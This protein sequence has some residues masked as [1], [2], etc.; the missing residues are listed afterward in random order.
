MAKPTAK[1]SPKT[2]SVYPYHEVV[3]S[4]GL[5]SDAWVRYKADVMAFESAFRGKLMS[6]GFT[7][8]TAHLEE[9]EGDEV[10]LGRVRPIPEA[11]NATANVTA[12]IK[13]MIVGQSFAERAINFQRLLDLVKYL[14]SKELTDLFLDPTI[15]QPHAQGWTFH[16]LERREFRHAAA[17]SSSPSPFAVF[18]SPR[19]GPASDVFSLGCFLHVIWVGKLPKLELP[20]PYMSKIKRVYIYT[21]E[22]P[23]N[24]L[25]SCAPNEDVHLRVCNLINAACDPDPTNRPKLQEF[26]Q[27]FN[28]IA[29]EAILFDKEACLFWKKYFPND[30][31]PRFDDFMKHFVEHFGIAERV[32]S[33]KHFEIKRRVMQY[34]VTL[35]G[36]DSVLIEEFS[37]V[38]FWFGPLLP[39]EDV[40]ENFLWR[41]EDQLAKT[42][43]HGPITAETACVLLKG[44]QAGSYLI[45]FSG[46][47]PGCYAISNVELSDGNSILHRR[48]YRTSD[49]KFTVSIADANAQVYDSIEAFLLDCANRPNLKHTFRYPVG[50]SEYQNIFEEYQRRMRDYHGRSGYPTDL[51]DF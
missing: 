26:I 14:H 24:T 20:E 32:R 37:R 42:A 34:L 2:G 22:K 10:T 51:F 8:E 13:K 30:L 36:S 44:K 11:A 48:F 19:D 6:L 4:A 38:V 9:V 23:L 21:D 29:I 25:Y 47:I 45:R 16:G 1:F 46:T 3:T 40:E 18:A 35:A 43:F 39:N 31:R 28:E 7:V 27:R 49:G 5:A 33:E 50:G 12:H 15:V 17:L 41:I